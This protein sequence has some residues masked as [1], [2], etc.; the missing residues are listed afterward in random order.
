MTRRGSWRWAF[1]LATLASSGCYWLTSYEDLTDGSVAI[2]AST[3]TAAPL[4]DAAPLR[5]CATV[6]AAFCDDFDDGTFDAWAGIQ[7]MAPDR[8][9]LA[10]AALSPPFAMLASIPAEGGTTERVY[11][12][13]KLPEGDAVEVAF[14]VHLDAVESFEDVTFLAE[15]TANG[16]NLDLWALPGVANVVEAVAGKVVTHGVAWDPVFGKEATWVHVRFG[17]DFADGGAA[18]LAADD[19]STTF[20]LAPG[21][22]RGQVRLRLG[23]IRV[24]EPYG[25]AVRYDNVVGRI[26]S[27]T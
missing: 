12:E 26:R 17:I 25:R 19:A 22:R 10:D 7:V 4:A 16:A 27:G 20:A 8:L 18:T 5:F 15:L 11:V 24:N 14:D 1:A 9:A 23:F 3:D 13:T 6:D 21:W 2:D